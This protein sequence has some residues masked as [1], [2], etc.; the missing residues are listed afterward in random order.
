MTEATRT[1]NVA[2][3][4]NP[5]EISKGHDGRTQRPMGDGGLRWD[6]VPLNKIPLRLV[7]ARC[8]RQCRTQRPTGWLRR[9]LAWDSLPFNQI[10]LKPGR[11]TMAELS[12]LRAAAATYLGLNKIPLKPVRARW[13]NLAPYG[14]RRGLGLVAVQ[15]NPTETCSFIRT[16]RWTNGCHSCC[17]CPN[18]KAT[19]HG[20]PTAASPATAATAAARHNA[21]LLPR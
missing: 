14:R 17:T 13:P 20:A 3:L 5:T 16:K 2:I 7:R 19:R 18:S 4:Q 15:Q 12:A 10:P 1:G 9:R 11:G 21:T 6:S 8:R